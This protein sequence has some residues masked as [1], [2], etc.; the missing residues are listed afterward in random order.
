ME[1]LTFQDTWPA[2]A[3]RAAG[4]GHLSVEMVAGESAATCVRAASPLK[5]LVPRSRGASVWAYLSSY[6]GGMV[7][8]DRTRLTVQVADGASCYLS[9]QATTKIYKN[10]E[11]RPCGH[12]LDAR[13]GHGAVL[14]LIPDPVQAYAGSIYCQRQ[15]FDLE[16]GGGLALV[17][18]VS[19]GRAARGERWAFNH[20]ES[21]NE[22][23]QNGQR[24]FL[25]SLWLDPADGELIGRHRLGRFNHVALALLLGD[26]MREPAARL[27][28]SLAAEPVRRQSELI[29]SASAVAGGA[30][31][32]CAGERVEAV[33]RFLHG[34]LAFLAGLLHDDPWARKW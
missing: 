1:L 15:R 2:S 20:F 32:R 22:V 26:A 21:R 30:L 28:A 34:H 24:T 16:P 14:A 7:A 8:G 10:P 31:L 13:I 11:G 25:D 19:A 12:Q 6:G 4:Q 9:T 18:W 23:F 5:I 33:G 27:L 17:D 29:F 3:N